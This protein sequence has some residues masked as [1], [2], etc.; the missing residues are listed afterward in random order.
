MKKC[1]REMMEEKEEIVKKKKHQTYQKAII[2][3]R[4]KDVD[5]VTVA[6]CLP[7]LPPFKAPFSYPQSLYLLHYFVLSPRATFSSTSIYILVLILPKYTL[8]CFNLLPFLYFFFSL[9]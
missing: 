2:A 3:N 6:A 8:F 4:G 9:I 1:K 7:A 5:I